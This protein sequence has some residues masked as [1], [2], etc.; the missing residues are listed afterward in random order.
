MAEAPLI[1]RGGLVVKPREVERMLLRHPAVAEVAVV[2]LPDQF[3]DE[4]VAAVIRLSAPLPTAV[5]ELTEHCRTLLAPHKVPVRWVFASALPHTANGEICRL[6]VT[7]Q[8]ATLSGLSEALF[9]QRAATEDL[10]IPLQVRRSWTP[11]D[12]E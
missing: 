11:D 1:V 5:A 3:W 6:T 4:I 8:A 9:Q 2:G 12:L 7:A 10:R